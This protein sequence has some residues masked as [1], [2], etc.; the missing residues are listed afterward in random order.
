MGFVAACVPVIPRFFQEPKVARFIRRWILFGP[1]TPV[2]QDQAQIMRS[3]HGSLAA[4]LSEESKMRRG[5]AVGATRLP[6]LDRRPG[7]AINSS[8]SS[9]RDGD[10]DEIPSLLRTY[11]IMKTVD[12]TMSVSSQPAD[13]DYDP[14][15]LWDQ[16]SRSAMRPETT[17][18]QL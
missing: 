4:D 7:E 5:Y 12:I 10:D 16:S 11:G 9:M 17:D 14:R 18:G 1:S 15:E 3:W 13:V 2:P 6:S 8:A